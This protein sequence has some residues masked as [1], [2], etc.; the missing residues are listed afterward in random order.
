MPRRVTQIRPGLIVGPRDNTD[1][2]T[3]WPV[4]IDRGG[5][6]LAPGKPSDLTQYIDVR[7][8]ARFMV[9]CL[10]QRLTDTY[11]V[12]RN[13]MPFG[14]FLSACLDTIDSDAE[15]TWVP[16]DFLAE[17]DVQPWRDVHL[18]ADSGSALA[19]SLTWS[20]GKA[21]SAGLAISPVE[22]TIRDTLAWYRSLPVERRSG[23]RAGMSPDKEASVLEAWHRFEQAEGS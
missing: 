20:A 1:R 22:D 18:W 13:P 14:D 4:R 12:V 16:A 9:H 10:E 6:V 17:H 3:Y 5:E 7:D 2:F 11:N 8:L 21:L 15:L 19:G 23:L